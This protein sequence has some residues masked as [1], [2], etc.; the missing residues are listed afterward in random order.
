M[1]GR[2]GGSTDEDRSSP[3]GELRE[4][5]VLLETSVESGILKNLRASMSAT[6]AIL[7]AGDEAASLRKPLGRWPKLERVTEET[8][9]GG[10]SR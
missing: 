5:R 9:R 6:D 7:L 3:R 4:C 8:S 1:S 10:A 2:V